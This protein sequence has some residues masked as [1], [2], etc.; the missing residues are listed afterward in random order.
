MVY[1]LKIVRPINKFP[2]ES[3]PQLEAV[4]NDLMENEHHLNDLVADSPKRSNI[5]EVKGHASNFPCEYCTSKAVRFY[6]K[7]I[8]KV[9]DTYEKKKNYSGKALYFKLTS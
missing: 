9:C 2:L 8:K 1:P 4:L 7:D 5:K 6:E 3:R